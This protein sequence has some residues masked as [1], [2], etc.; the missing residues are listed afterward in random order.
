MGV[1]GV[2]LLAIFWWVGEVLPDWAVA[3]VMMNLWVL[4]GLTGFDVAFKAYTNSTIWLIVGA[5]CLSTAVTK[6]GFIKRVTLQLMKL[7][8]PTFRGQVLAMLLVGTVC[9][10]LIPSATARAVLGGTL[11]FSTAGAMGYGPESRGR[12]GLFIAAFV[13]F[14]CVSPAFL[15]SGANSYCLLG[16]LPENYRADVSFVSWFVA[17]I[18]WLLLVLAGMF[19]L[20]LMLYRPK[21]DS[22]VTGSFVREELAQ[23]GSMS[24]QEKEA[25]LILCVC[26][27]FWVMEKRLGVDSA[28]VAMTG[29]LTCF[30]LGI[31]RPAEVSTA[32]PW[33]LILFLGGALN[34][35]TVF[36][37]VGVDVWLQAVMTPFFASLSNRYLLVVVVWAAVMLI[38][39]LLI[40]QTATVTL[41]TTILSTVIG[42]VGIHPFVIG[43]V[44][45]A[46]MEC[47]FVYYQNVMYIPGLRCMENTISHG[48]NI[49]AC[50]GY[51]LVSLAALLVSVP[52]W[53]LLGY[54]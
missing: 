20:I 44:I 35:G 16:A 45:Y 26:L 2:L 17:M 42:S 34:I 47:W 49:K 27:F 46:T 6:T 22:A 54:L 38:R 51:E 1:L 30:A 36:K 8:K 40:S 25:A 29:G 7:F 15:T 5:F 13:G 11:A 32:I 53:G 39:F 33:N 31:L 28:C 14:Y 10:P 4:L 43:L 48:G 21:K 52:Y 23:L 9:C 18:P 41:L 24:R 12:Y 50:V 19:V 37:A 3:L